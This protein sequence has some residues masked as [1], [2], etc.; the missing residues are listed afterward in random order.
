MAKTIP[1]VRLDGVIA[2]DA[3][4]PGKTL[5]LAGIEP[6]LKAAFDMKKAPCVA[7]VI[8][9]P[10]GSPVQSSLIG[11]RIRQL[12]QDKKKPV[13]AFIEDVAASGGYWLACAADEIIVDETSIVGSIGVI[14]ASFGLQDAIA[15]LGVERRVY[16]AGTTKSQLDPFRAEDAEQVARWKAKLDELHQVFIAH[17]KA[18]RGARLHPDPLM[19]EGEIFIGAHAVSLGLADGV[20]ALHT[21]LAERY[22]DSVKLKPIKLQKPG[23][24]SRLFAGAAADAA[25]CAIAQLEARALWARYGL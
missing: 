2:A 1:V 6:A 11:K 7:L 14:S 5:S 19:F 21:V 18:R 4:G 16:T 23:L 17:V 25:A 3:I 8:N 10:G 13:V 22:G 24:L 9:S 12:S 20:G 15:R